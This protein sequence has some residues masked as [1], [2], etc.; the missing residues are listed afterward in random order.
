[1]S[2]PRV[3]SVGERFCADGS[4]LHGSQRKKL[5]QAQLPEAVAPETVSFPLKRRYITTSSLAMSNLITLIKLGQ[6][7]M[8][9]R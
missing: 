3:D 8:E 1:M 2:H 9:V 5:S 7:Q 4:P 6:R